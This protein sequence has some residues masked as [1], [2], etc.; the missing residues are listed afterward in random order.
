MIV[1]REIESFILFFRTKKL[2]LGLVKE[3]ETKETQ[4]ERLKNSFEASSLGKWIFFLFLQHFFLP[5]L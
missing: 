4:E 2:L 3:R 5:P 1:D